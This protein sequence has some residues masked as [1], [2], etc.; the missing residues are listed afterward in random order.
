MSERQQHGGDPM[1]VELLKNGSGFF[2]GPGKRGVGDCWEVAIKLS[3]DPDIR[4]A[5]AWDKSEAVDH[6][7][8]RIETMLAGLRRMKE[9]IQLEPENE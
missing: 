3:G 7:I 9:S 5:A 4:L 8:G 1:R 2:D 6:A